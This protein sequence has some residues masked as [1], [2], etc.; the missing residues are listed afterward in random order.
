MP[1]RLLNDEQV[2]YL[3]SISEG[4]HIEEIKDMLNKRFGTNFTFEQIK[5]LKGK[6]KIHSHLKC[7]GRFHYRLTTQ[8]QDDWMKE[9]CIGTSYKWIQQAFKEQF[10]IE[11]TYSQ[12]KGWCGRKR[13][14]L[15]VSG[16][17]KKGHVPH[18]KGKKMSPEVYAKCAPSMFK[19]GNTPVNH[20]PVGSERITVEGYIEVKVAEPRKWR[21]KH[22]VVYEEHFGPIPKG[23]IVVFADNNKMNLD[24]SNLLL[25]T[26]NENARLNQLGL[27]SDIAEVTKA[28]LAIARLAIAKQKRRKEK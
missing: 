4:R 19:K 2:A 1:K 5:N 8:E 9:H 26:R 28:G 22:V 27:R 10:G 17:F 23:H 7:N 25:I 21:P 6:L 13:V 11:L 24:P 12:V 3:R 15:G 18:N 20:R 14:C 16:C